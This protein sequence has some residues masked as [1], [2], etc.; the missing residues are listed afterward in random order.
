MA[1]KK[2]EVLRERAAFSSAAL[3]AVPPIWRISMQMKGKAN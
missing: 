3:A 1:A 2:V